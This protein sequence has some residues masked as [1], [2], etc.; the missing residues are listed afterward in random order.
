MRRAPPSSG[1]LEPQLKTNALI[2]TP[3]ANVP[4]LPDARDGGAAGGAVIIGTAGSTVGGR[5]DGG[6]GGGVGDAFVGN[7]VAGLR[8]D[9]ALN[10][11]RARSSQTQ[12]L[13]SA[14]GNR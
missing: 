9:G 8:R 5:V 3:A 13:S 6:A 12:E 11:L 10:G 2:G 7:A 14:L 1:A 4:L